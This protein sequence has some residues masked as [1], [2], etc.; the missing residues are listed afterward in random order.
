MKKKVYRV[1]KKMERDIQKNK[2]EVCQE[3]Q[4]GQVNYECKKKRY[5]KRHRGRNKKNL[6]KTEN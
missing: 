2:I 4:R 5:Y 1:F 6:F 3:L